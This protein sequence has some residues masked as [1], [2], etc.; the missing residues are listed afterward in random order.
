MIL[1]IVMIIAAMASL[2]VLY[3]MHIHPTRFLCI[4]QG[5][6]DVILIVC[7]VLWVLR[8]VGSFL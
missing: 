4:S 1:D 7:L 6:L 3:H 8:I 2:P 5:I